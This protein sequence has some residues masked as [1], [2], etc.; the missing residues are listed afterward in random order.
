[1]SGQEGT[2]ST[3]P[4]DYVI[5][6]PRVVRYA[7]WCWALG[8]IILIGSGWQIYNQEP[9]FPSFTFPTWATIGLGSW[10]GAERVH[11]DIGLAGALLWHFAAMWL[12]F[13]SITV[14]VIYG[15]VSGHFHRKF[16]PVWPS[17]VLSDIGDFFHGHLDHELGARNAIQKLLYAFAVCAML[18]MVWTG[19]VLWKPVQFDFLGGPLGEYEGARYLHF[20]GM[21]GIVLFIVVHVALTLLVPKVLPP[22]ITGKAR[23]SKVAAQ[24]RG[25]AS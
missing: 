15:I 12:L 22:M 14:Y 4:D 18:L 6:H 17:Q 10:E 7:H 21:A 9:I 3:V 13:I 19:L 24:L 8:V 5:L 23:R 1:M 11:N 25:E 2:R 16:L 20:F